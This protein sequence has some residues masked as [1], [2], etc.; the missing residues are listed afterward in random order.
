[1]GWIDGE[2]VTI[3]YRWAEGDPERLPALVAEFIQLKVDVIVLSGA[4]AIRA[5]QNATRRRDLPF[6]RDAFDRL[7][8]SA[9][10]NVLIIRFIG[11][12]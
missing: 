7:S 4:A 9:Q 8:V 3:D 11:Y 6:R 1:L 5:A 2:N 12:R 10:R